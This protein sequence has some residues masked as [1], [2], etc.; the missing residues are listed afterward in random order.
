M[1]FLNKI[2]IEMKTTV[3]LPL[4]L[5]LSQEVQ[6]SSNCNCGIVNENGVKN[7]IING[8]VTAPHKYPWQVKLRGSEDHCGGTLITD[9]GSLQMHTI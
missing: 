7:R 9:K 6:S 4:L 5:F 3:L 8:S 2:C 1:L